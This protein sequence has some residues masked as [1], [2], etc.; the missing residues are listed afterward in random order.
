MAL[1]FEFTDEK[2]YNQLTKDEKS[3]NDVFIW[4]MMVVGLGDITEKNAKEWQWRYD[5]ASKLTGP[6][7]YKNDEPYIPTLEEV[8]KRIGLRTNNFPAKTRKQFIAA[9]ARLASKK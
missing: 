9:Q 1:N 2:K 7:F 6:F 5:F 8:E 4:G 3:L